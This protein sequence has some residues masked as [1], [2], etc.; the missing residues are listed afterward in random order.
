MKEFIAI[1][2]LSIV[3]VLFGVF[4]VTLGNYIGRALT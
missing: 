2:M 4:F 1:A 3:G